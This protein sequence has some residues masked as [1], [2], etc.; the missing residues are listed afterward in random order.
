MNVEIKF[1]VEEC[2]SGFNVVLR[3]SVLKTPLQRLLVMPT[4]A[5]AEAIAAEWNAQSEKIKPETMLLTKFANTAIDAV[6]GKMDE[7]RGSIVSYLSTDLLFYRAERPDDLARRQ[8]RA[9]DPLL[10]SLQSQGM[11]FNITWGL[12]PV[13]QPAESLAAYAD[14]IAPYDAF[15]LSGLSSA[16]TLT[17]SAILA[18]ALAE[19]VLDVEAVWDAAH[20]DEDFQAEQWG[21]DEDASARRA[22]RWKEMEA[23][24]RLLALLKA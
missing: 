14:K 4:R 24:A 11:I 16:T 18:L 1:L 19:N 3:G 20:I 9:Y 5:L 10:T 12:M 6:T 23:A 17:G 8:S 13:T 22:E 7:V 21:R 2:A 15:K